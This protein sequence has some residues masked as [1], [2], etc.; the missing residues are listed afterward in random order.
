MKQLLS[1]QPDDQTLPTTY[2]FEHK[3]LLCC[4]GTT[5]DAKRQQRIKALVKENLNWEYLIET[6]SR[7]SVLPLLYQTL[8]TTC[9]EAIPNQVLD[10][11]QTR[12]RKNTISNLLSTAEMCR[13]VRLFQS[14][15]IEVIPFKGPT[16][17]LSAYGDL[18]LRQFHD[19]DFLIRKPDVLQ[20]KEILLAEKYKPQVECNASTIDTNHEFP[21]KKVAYLELQTEMLHRKFAFAINDD[22]LWQDLVEL[23][24]DGTV[25]H[26]LSPENLLV[27]LC[28]HGT[29]SLWKRL[30]WICDIAE[31]IGACQLNWDTVHRRAQTLG[32]KR[33]IRLGLCLAN[34]LLGAQLPDQMLE[35]IETDRV[36]AKLARQTIDNLFHTST[37]FYQEMDQGLFYI[38]SR[39]RLRDRTLCYWRMA[40]TPTE[41]DRRLIDLPPR[42]A[43]LY[44][45]LRPLRLIGKR[46][47]FWL[48]QGFH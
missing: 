48:K 37:N 13:L 19:I 14:H 45:G 26:T 47:Q 7:Q 5:L 31:L 24:I 18:A 46:L 28:A 2:Q 9:R 23:D 25:V 40:T 30:I 4:A 32:A 44:Y 3:L 43:F 39:E 22:D 42:L 34:N 15:K 10:Q 16:L 35:E 41:I 6:A 1:F 17:A 38:Q 36:V 29:Q 11:L 21:F 12:F 8:N 33:M 20:A 27:V